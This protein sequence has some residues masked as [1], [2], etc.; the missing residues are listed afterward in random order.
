M[1]LT[2]CFTAITCFNAS[3][4]AC[5]DEVWESV[6]ISTSAHTGICNAKIQDCVFEPGNISIPVVKYIHAV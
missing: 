1:Y 4:V 3:S 6:L 5:V 2:L